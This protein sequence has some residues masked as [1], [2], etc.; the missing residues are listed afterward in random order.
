MKYVPPETLEEFVFDLV[1]MRL[2]K[3]TRIKLDRKIRKQKKNRR[4]L[5]RDP[6]RYAHRELRLEI[7]IRDGYRCRYCG[8][9]VS[10][11]TANMDHVRPWKKGG[12]T[13]MQNLVAA[14]RSCNKAKG[15]YLD[16][17]PLPLPRIKAVILAKRN[18]KL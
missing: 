6:V 5:S 14:C 16:W 18:E 10:D 4:R 17:K 8:V 15:N 3:K 13:K 11:A 12:K 2:S 7:L 1:S 9:S